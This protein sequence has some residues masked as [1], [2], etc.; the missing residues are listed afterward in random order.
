[1]LVASAPTFLLAWL[2]RRAAA[3]SF[4]SPLL[5][6]SMLILTGLMLFSVRKTASLRGLK[7]M[8]WSDALLI[9]VFQGVAI[10]PGISRSGMTICAGLLR[11]LKR[12][13]AARFAFLVAIPA[14]CAAGVYEGVKAAS[15]LTSAAVGEAVFGAGIAALSGY[16][17]LKAVIKIVQRGEIS[18]FAYYLWIFGALA[19][20]L[21]L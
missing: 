13:L 19:I 9:G 15:S 1:V 10:F 8:K 2:L 17:A 7:E 6:A 5:A 11:G 14:V 21:Q 4:Q 20:I 12:P 16:F 3:A 18:R